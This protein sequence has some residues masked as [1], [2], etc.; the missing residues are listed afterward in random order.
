MRTCIHACIHTYILYYRPHA[1]MGAWC[2]LDAY[3]RKLRITIV[4]MMTVM[5]VLATVMK[6][7]MGTRM[8]QQMNT[9]TDITALIT[10]IVMFSINP[11]VI[12]TVR[13][14]VI[15]STL[16]ITIIIAATTESLLTDYSILFRSSCTGDPNVMG[17]RG[18]EACGDGREACGYIATRNRCNDRKQGKPSNNSVNS[19]PV[20]RTRTSHGGIVTR[21]RRRKRTTS[22][23]PQVL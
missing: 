10:I 21:R 6:V 4:E 5:M 13:T 22:T 2:I 3:V 23:N 14:V 11:I 16:I 19:Q 20:I 9:K 18:R 12:I 7:R 8:N 1:C 17:E 15:I